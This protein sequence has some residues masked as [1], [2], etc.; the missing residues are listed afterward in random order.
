VEKWN[1]VDAANLEREERNHY[2][3]YLPY[4]SYGDTQTKEQQRARA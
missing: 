4:T 3:T 1:I 2:I